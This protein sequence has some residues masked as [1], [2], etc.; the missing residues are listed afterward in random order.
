MFELK[1]SNFLAPLSSGA[2]PMPLA[3]KKIFASA[4]TVLQNQFVGLGPFQKVF[5]ASG[6]EQ[7][8]LGSPYL[9]RLIAVL[10]F[11]L[12]AIA[13]SSMEVVLC[14]TFRWNLKFR[15]IGYRPIV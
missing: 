8:A 5:R 12:D 14:N 1:I 15:G 9:F 4:R 6:V 2:G 10:N 3:Y 11:L 7:A 13:K